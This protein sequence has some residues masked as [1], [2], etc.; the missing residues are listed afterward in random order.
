M[1][2]LP[3]YTLRPTGLSLLTQYEVASVVQSKTHL[4]D[5]NGVKG[6]ARSMRIKVLGQ[7]NLQK[8]NPVAQLPPIW[9]FP[10]ITVPLT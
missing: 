3:S 5:G 10:V 6:K 1:S 9:K 8:G 7:L 2:H 4:N